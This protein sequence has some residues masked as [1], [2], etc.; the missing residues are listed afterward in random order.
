MTRIALFLIAAALQAACV[1]T[2]QTGLDA[3][4]AGIVSFAPVKQDRNGSCIVGFTVTY[5]E[6]ISPHKRRITIEE[7][8]L[9]TSSSYDLPMPA[10]GPSSA[11]TRQGAMVTFTGLGEATVVDCNPEL[12]RRTL[13][14]G[15]CTQGRCATA[16]FV[17]DASL[18]GLGLNGRVLE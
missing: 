6:G 1:P 10:L 7:P 11:F 8:A 9:S 12:T 18:A 16:R 14:V 13:T 5:P 15:A 17:P 4:P 3:P 2:D